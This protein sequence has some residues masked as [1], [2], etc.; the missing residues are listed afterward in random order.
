MGS[1]VNQNSGLAKRIAGLQD[2]HVI[3]SIFYDKAKPWIFSDRFESL[4]IG[5][6]WGRWGPSRPTYTPGVGEG[7][8]FFDAVTEDWDRVRWTVSGVR[9][10]DRFDKT[11]VRSDRDRF[12]G[13]LSTSVPIRCSKN[14]EHRFQKSSAWRFRPRPQEGEVTTITFCFPDRRRLTELLGVGGQ[15]VD[16]CSANY[17]TSSLIFNPWITTGKLRRKSISRRRRMHMRL[18]SRDR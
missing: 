3:F 13:V 18:Q 9:Q 8:R 1:A 14:R 11:V 6:G 15:G 5:L 10:W 12:R 17:V 16:A 4:G 2:M 7:D